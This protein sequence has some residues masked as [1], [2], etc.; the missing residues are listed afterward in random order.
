MPPVQHMSDEAGEPAVCMEA[1]KILKD[2]GGERVFH[3]NH[4]KL[5]INIYLKTIIRCTSFIHKESFYAAM[6]VP[7]LKKDTARRFYSYPFLWDIY[8]LSQEKEKCNRKN[9]ELIEQNKTRRSYWR[10]W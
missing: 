6:V 8:S 1:A 7:Q 4:L 10:S 9:D 2:R 5:V 3:S